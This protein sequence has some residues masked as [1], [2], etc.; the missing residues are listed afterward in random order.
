MSLRPPDEATQPLEPAN[1]TDTRAVPTFVQQLLQAQKMA[2][3]AVPQIAG[4]L[5]QVA[6]LLW[7]LNIAE[8]RRKNQVFDASI[9]PSP[10]G[11]CR[12]QLDA[13]LRNHALPNH[14]TVHTTNL[15]MRFHQAL[16]HN[17]S[18]PT[19]SMPAQHDG[20]DGNAAAE[21]VRSPLAS[22]HRRAGS[23]LEHSPRPGPPPP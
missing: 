18:H 5:G 21:H 6:P 10:A 4:D 8:P 20:V 22:A 13:K 14:H 9:R 23:I 1:L 2:Q 12:A 3:P 15:R 16:V 19:E 7:G 17:D 11:V